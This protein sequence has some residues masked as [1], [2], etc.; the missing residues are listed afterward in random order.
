MASSS[1]KWRPRRSRWRSRHPEG[2]RSSCRSRTLSSAGC[3]GAERPPAP[4]SLR[5]E[6][7]TEELCRDIHG[8]PRRQCARSP[9]S[10]RA[11]TH[12]QHR[13]RL[14]QLRG[15]HRYHRGRKPP[16]LG[17]REGRCLRR[18]RNTKA[19][20]LPRFLDLLVICR[21]TIPSG[22]QRG[23]GGEPKRAVRGARKRQRFGI[24]PPLSFSRPTE[25]AP[26]RQ[27]CSTTKGG[28]RTNPLLPGCG[29]NGHGAAMSGQRPPDSPGGAGRTVVS[30]AL[31]RGRSRLGW[32]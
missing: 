31:C 10:Q 26:S 4:A 14:P 16:L 3:G 13:G 19:L 12:Q 21:N 20:L 1:W 11:D 30:R 28:R 17:A 25:A 32:D 22:L 15:S 8:K 18:V 29:F 5:A 7:P 23:R 24:S 9:W 6:P 27:R 2:H